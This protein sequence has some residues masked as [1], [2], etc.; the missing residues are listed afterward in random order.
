MCQTTAGWRL[1]ET[2][3]F[4]QGSAHPLHPKWKFGRDQVVT[5]KRNKGRFSKYLG[6]KPERD[7]KIDRSQGPK[8]KLSPTLKKTGSE[9]ENIP[10]SIPSSTPLRSQ[11]SKYQNN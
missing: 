2:L 7:V 5:K 4:L 9:D 8:T 6:R 11:E 10:P 3:V 1:K